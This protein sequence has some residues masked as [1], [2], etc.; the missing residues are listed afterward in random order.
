[1]VHPILSTSVDVNLNGENHL[2]TMPFIIRNTNA[3]WIK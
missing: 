2:M 1:M 3:N